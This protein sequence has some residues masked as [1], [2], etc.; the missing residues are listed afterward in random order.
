MQASSYFC[1][2]RRLPNIEVNIALVVISEMRGPTYD[3]GQ[4][5]L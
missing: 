2:V 1:L 4:A 3:G 5:R